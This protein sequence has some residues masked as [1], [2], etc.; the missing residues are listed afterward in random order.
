MC[1]S[2]AAC[3]VLALHTRMVQ[4]KTQGTGHRNFPQPLPCPY[5]ALPSLREGQWRKDRQCTVQQQRHDRRWREISGRLMAGL[6]RIVTGIRHALGWL[7]A[8][9]RRIPRWVWQLIWFLVTLIL[10]Y[11]PQIVYLLQLIFHQKGP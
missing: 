7:K 4:V 1:S 5:I 2:D 6:L 10:G 11:L 8:Q 3:I 9:V